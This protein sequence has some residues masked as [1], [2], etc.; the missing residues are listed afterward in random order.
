MQNQLA[1]REKPFGNWNG[2]WNGNELAT[3]WQ[4]DR[5]TTGQLPARPRWAAAGR[6]GPGPVTPARAKPPR[7]PAPR[8]AGAQNPCFAPR[9]RKLRWEERL[10]A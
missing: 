7:Q 8:R 1:T 6:A 5:A 9:V 4:L 2:N 10:A 3:D